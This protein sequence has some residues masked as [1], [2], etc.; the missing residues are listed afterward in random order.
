[1][2]IGKVFVCFLLVWAPA[3]AGTIEIK[4]PEFCACDVFQ[5]LKRATCQSRKLVSIELNIPAHAEILDISHN[6]ISNLGDKIFLI[7][8]IETCLTAQSGSDFLVTSTGLSSYEPPSNP[9]N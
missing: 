9:S 5:G 7:E 3:L 1:M 2:K 8:L 6:Q 4:C